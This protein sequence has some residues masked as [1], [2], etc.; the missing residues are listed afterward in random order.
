MGNCEKYNSVQKM[1]DTV[2]K[3]KSVQNYDNLC[4]TIRKL[5]KIMINCIQIKCSK[6]RLFIKFLE[7]K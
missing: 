4:R 1:W 2:H 3:L 6:L 5:C 7:G